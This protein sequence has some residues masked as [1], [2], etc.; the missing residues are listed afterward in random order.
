[1]KITD[2]YPSRNDDGLP[3]EGVHAWAEEKYRLVQQYSALFC[4]AMKGKWQS[5][6]Y[7]DLFSGPGRSKID[8]K[9]IIDAIPLLVA[10]EQPKYDKY[11]FCDVD[12]DKCAAL[13]Q[14]LEQQALVKTFEVLNGDANLITRDILS[15]I[16]PHNKQHTV[17]G[18]CFVDPY[19][20]ENLKFTTIQ[21][22][23]EKFIDFLVLIP[24]GMDA[25]RNMAHYFKP[26][27]KKL[28]E[29]LGTS[30]WR[31]D[32]P[33]VEQGN[34]P[35]EMFIAQQFSK[36]MQ[37]LGYIDPGLEN[38]KLIRS[39]EKNLPLYRLALYSRH[40]LGKKFWQ[41]TIEYTQPQ[42]NLDFYHGNEFTY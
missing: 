12:K 28:D 16:P 10:A 1:M 6:V 40:E 26:G 37:R 31:T 41:D 4:K 21:V 25:N 11:I 24:T 30:N 23:S 34:T 22:L 35:R 39:V 18:F 29:F 42:R 13:Q 17:L 36:S 33:D 27:N 7:I 14:R 38:M 9:R 5:L 20:I 8:N 3:I 32:W 2:E 15:L 19:R